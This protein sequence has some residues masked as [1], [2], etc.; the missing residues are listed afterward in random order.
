MF[1]LMLL[2]LAAAVSTSPTSDINIPVSYQAGRVMVLART[3]NGQTLNLWVD[4]GGGGGSGMYLLTKESAGRLHLKISRL[5]LDRQ[6]VPVAELPKF[7]PG[8]GVPPPAG[9]YARVMLIPE[10]G[11]AGPGDTTHYDGMLGAGY[12]PGSVETHERIWTF[13]Y[14]RQ[15]LTLQGSGWRPHAAARPTPLHFPL[16]A[17]GQLESGFARI[18]VHVG[19]TSLSLLLDT[20]A[21]GYPTP[22]ALAAQGGTAAVRAT[23][24]ITTSQL[25][26]WHKAHPRW[27]VVEDADRL[28]PKGKPMRAIEVPDVVV[29]GWHAGPVWFTERP[30]ANFHDFMSSMMDNQVEGALGGNLFDHFVMTVDYQ[31][32]KAWFR[33]VRG[34]K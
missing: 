16:N 2:A 29:A 28:R 14:P 3:T 33:C 24:F 5:V 20:G 1:S 6:A 11:L 27:R 32:S 22:V 21:T 30:D 15:H 10:K 18:V 8:A 34:C 7:A 13:D 25:E 17:Q 26:H 9:K 12:L 19:G 31:E 23:S 4:T